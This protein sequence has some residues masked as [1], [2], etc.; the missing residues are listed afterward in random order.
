VIS[1]GKLEG[2]AG[3]QVLL[4][5]LAAL[6]HNVGKLDGNF[7]AAVVTEADS[8]N[9]AEC[10]KDHLLRINDY[11]FRRFAAPDPALFGKIGAILGAENPTE[12][13]V[14]GLIRGILSSEDQSAIH[15]LEAD[16]QGAGLRYPELKRIVVA[17]QRLAKFW[18]GNGPLY[19]L[20]RR[21][22]RDRIRQLT[23]ELGD[24]GRRQSDPSTPLAD[25]QNEGARRK[26][27]AAALADLNKVLARGPEYQKAQEDKFNALSIDVGGEM[28]RLA[29]LLTVFWDQFNYKPEGKDLERRPAL[30]RWI[31]TQM[32]LPMLLALA[33]GAASGEKGGQ[34]P[35]AA[36]EGDGDGDDDGP[37]LRTEPAKSSWDHLRFATA[38]GYEDEKRGVE[39]WALH[40]RRHELLECALQAA[41][42]PKSERVEFL[43]GA[44]LTLQT[45][46]A[47]TKRPL[48]DITLW[49]Y[50]WTIASLFKATVAGAV[51]AEAIPLPLPANA[52][53]CFLS[54]ACDGLRFVGRAHSTADAIGRLKALE[55]AFDRVRAVLELQIP[56]GNEVYRDRNRSVFVVP[57]MPGLLELPTAVGQTLREVLLSAFLESGICGELVPEIAVGDAAQVPKLAGTLREA[58]ADPRG[59]QPDL[60]QAEEWWSQGRPP[61]AEICTVCGLRP[62]GYPRDGSGDEAGAP[63]LLSD[64]ERAAA[65]GMCQICHSRRTG[66]VEQWLRA[67]GE[68]EQAEQDE[69]SAIE[70]N[71]HERCCPLQPRTIWMDEVAD[72]HGRLALVTAKFDLDLWLDGTL[73]TTIDKPTSLAIIHRFWETT[74]QFWGAVESSVIPAAVGGPKN[75]LVIVP[76]NASQLR[77]VLHDLHAYDAFIDGQRLPVVWEARRG[78]FLSIDNL[79]YVA[80]Q[81]GGDP[82]GGARMVMERISRCAEH[83]QGVA[84]R[85]PGEYGRP[86]QGL[87]SYIRDPAIDIDPAFAY[88]PYIP[89]L[90]DPTRFM[91]L[92]PAANALAVVKGIRDK[93]QMEMAR[94]RD[95]LP[96]HIGLV[97]AHR[98]TPLR[99]I[100]DAGRAMAER[101]QEWEEWEVQD[102]NRRCLTLRRGNRQVTWCYPE[103]MGDGQTKDCWYPHLLVQPPPPFRADARLARGGAPLEDKGQSADRLEFGTDFKLIDGSP[104]APQDPKR[105]QVDGLKPGDHVWILPS[106]LDFEFLDSTARRFEVA[107]DQRGVRLGK[108]TRPYLLDDLAC[109]EELWQQ[110]SQLKRSQ[111]HAILGVIEETRGDWRAHDA[112]K[113]FVRFVADTLANAEW[114]RR[115]GQD[116][117]WHKWREPQRDALIAAGVSGVL[118][119][120][121]ELHFEILKEREGRY[122]RA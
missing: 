95:R 88:H 17:A 14:M 24:I 64:Q 72:E 119:D 22:E 110:F 53:C 76:G 39:W 3:R 98:H 117:R 80:A 2:E 18:R 89:I 62:Q 87:D 41:A 73:I 81:L 32:G 45:G 29:D 34:R 44:R 74:R 106:T 61:N 99:A 19:M 4:A 10:L 35:R 27:L 52:K 101:R 60:R 79:D 103:V 47:D 105:S 51:L 8:S 40:D 78:R 33:H 21:Q 86:A 42:D 109:Y 104:C 43:T 9:A 65:R 58:L 48:N 56:L 67:G 116:L 97:F 31:S 7:L 5:E 63:V 107:Y 25:K 121:A 96:A 118:A 12:R 11:S 113:A 100:L 20:P 70:D 36:D 111:I 102:R 122:E 91:A 38:F 16:W 115:D 46:L 68:R 28:W 15:E 92:V 13:E 83:G 85:E 69:H 93:Y 108:P 6:L 112:D 50:A 59:A 120:L 57:A 30:S 55:D 23:T 114:P 66:R 71:S 75:R 54:L 82:R 90:A 1:L 84:L 37:Q 26:V 49:D 94:V 77:A